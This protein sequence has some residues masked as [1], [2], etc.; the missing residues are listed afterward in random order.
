M[1]PGPWK[2]GK[3]KDGVAWVC[4][5][6]RKEGS[7]GTGHGVKGFQMVVPR[8]QRK[9]FSKGSVLHACGIYLLEAVPHY[10]APGPVIEVQYR[11]PK[12]GCQAA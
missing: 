12:P 3:V 8:S 10:T 9:Y 1:I 11:P 2:S 4:V 6:D 7:E 5:G